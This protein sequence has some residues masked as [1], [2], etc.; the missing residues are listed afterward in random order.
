[1]ANFI[2]YIFIYY[3]MTHHE[4]FIIIWQAY[5]VCAL[6]GASTVTI[7][8]LAL[9]SL[10]ALAGVTLSMLLRHIKRYFVVGK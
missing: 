1:M 6:G 9:A 7:S 8:F 3:I 10:Q 5:V 2:I 4:Y